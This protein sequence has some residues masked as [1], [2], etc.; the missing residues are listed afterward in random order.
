MGCG[1]SKLYKY[2]FLLF[3]EGTIKTMKIIQIMTLSLKQFRIYMK[4]LK[5][6]RGDQ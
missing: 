4:N 2:L 6:C 3:G 5:D 1:N